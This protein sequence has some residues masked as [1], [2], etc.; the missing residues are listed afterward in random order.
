MVTISCFSILSGLDE[1]W[2]YFSHSELT[3]SW[4]PWESPIESCVRQVLQLSFRKA[5]SV[6]C[7]LFPGPDEGVGWSGA[8]AEPEGRSVLG[9][10]GSRCPHPVWRPRG[11]ARL[12]Q[13]AL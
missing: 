12:P 4:P 11:S 2:G 6:C 8:P 10:S 7:F 5:A 13:R 1:E 9:R 3:E